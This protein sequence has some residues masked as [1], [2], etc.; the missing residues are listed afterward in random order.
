MASVGNTSAT[1]PI[2]TT[3]FDTA[4]CVIP[5]LNQCTEINTL[6]S[7][8]DKSWGRWPQHINLVY[9]FVHPEKLPE[10]K[11]RIEAALS[12]S[13][14]VAS[15]GASL[16]QPGYF[17][18]RK[19]YTVFL[20]ESD[21][22]TTALESLR[23]T[24]LE[25]LGQPSTPYKLHLTVG[26]SVDK[27]E[28]ARDFLLDKVRR[29]PC[30]KFPITSLAIL[31]RETPAK[32]QREASRM[33]LW[34]VIS[35]GSAEFIPKPSEFW[36]SY[37]NERGPTS[38]PDSAVAEHGFDGAH[39]L[40][41]DRR[42][43]SEVAYAYNQGTW[44]PC[45]GEECTI[46]L[47]RSL[48]VSSYNVLIDSEYPPAR[49]RDPL[50]LEAILSDT[51]AADILVLQEVSDDFLSY[52]LATPEIQRRY[53]YCSHGSPDQPDTGPLPNLRNIVLLSRM[54]FTWETVPFQ[55]RH[56]GALVA[57]FGA[58]ENGPSDFHFIVAG[59]HLTCGLTDGSVAAKKAQL[60]NLLSFLQQRHSTKPWIIAG[61]FNITTSTYTIEFALK[62]RSITQETGST[63]R[64]IETMIA[65]A[66]L[67][68]TWSV[69]RIEATD[70]PLPEPDDLYDGEFGATFNP[71]TNIL[72][73]ATS[74]TSNNRPQ[75]YDRILLRGMDKLRISQ[76]NHFG[77][78]GDKS[79]RSGTPSDHWGIRASLQLLPRTGD[80]AG[81]ESQ[82]LKHRPIDLQDVSTG[83]TDPWDLHAA[84]AA[85]GM[86]PTEENVEAFK[87]AFTRLKDVL[88]GP[89]EERM[90]QVPLVIIPVGSY[91]LDV[92]T[93][94]SDIDCL[95]VGTMSPKTFF[96]LARQRIR[97]AGVSG[98]RLIRKVEAKT[99]IMFELTV[100]GINV[101][102]QYCPG[103]RLL[104]RWS[105]LPN[106]HPTDPVFDLPM[107]SLR[108]LKPYRDLVYIQRTLPSL[109]AFRLAYRAIKLWALQRGVYS[110]KFGFLGG[111]HITLM[112]A[113]ICKGL[114]HVA[115]A[116]TAPALVKIFFHHYAHFDWKND[117]VFDPFFHK[118]RPRYHRS[119]REPMVVLGYHAPNSNAAHTSTGPGLATLVKEFKIADQRLSAVG[120]SWD[121]FFTVP[122]GAE[123]YLSEFLGSHD[124]YAQIS[125]QYWGRSLSRDKGLIGWVESRSLLLVVDIHKALPDIEV[126]I[127]PS[128]LSNRGPENTETGYEGCFV[129]GISWKSYATK[130]RRLQLFESLQ[131][132]FSRFLDTIR[133]EE[134]NYDRNTC[135]VD[136]SLVS[137]AQVKDLRPEST[138]W[139]DYVADADLD[140][141]DEED[142]IGNS[143]EDSHQPTIPY[144]PIR[145]P[146]TS[147][148]EVKSKLRPASDVL[149]RLRWDPGC[150]PGA[151]IVGY[152][153]R[154]VGAKEMDL[155]RWKSESTHDEFVP[156][157]RI[158][159]F[160]R[161]ADGVVVWD[162]N[163]RLDRIFGSGIGDRE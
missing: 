5:P 27:T 154:F 43:P 122:G 19:E 114:V 117:M 162:R 34:G 72:A 108:K 69:A 24:V 111:I 15:L 81:N 112:L 134:K 55:R 73:A 52:I 87:S 71:R 107:L 115:G 136:I 155:E 12:S 157:H 85:R 109:G 149:N 2:A 33:R 113:S 101:D 83:L 90:P 79:D 118:T 102:L 124:G 17:E 146:R 1:K 20:G 94:T 104:E 97:R 59:V 37:P 26:Q 25:A 145:P 143:N 22:P 142:D 9:P 95:C 47:D 29:L 75:R 49:E 32:H 135:W 45:A 129:I 133:G 156:M 39:A 120:M 21:S 99:G 103:G 150:N 50:L 58:S 63:L 140:S 144:V 141:D 152:E 138:D 35:L 131:K 110:S 89:T 56:K 4:L 91:A 130:D 70:D 61:D 53:P 31:V 8:Y 65:E 48:T 28:A 96:K 119:A 46:N 82:P 10:A 127:W 84:L 3:S 30:L 42:A 6:R 123:N 160:R 64:N 77:L 76:F 68:D 132:A 62:H 121:Q 86:I 13:A 128:R 44:A 148:V 66:E 80:C 60:Q 7:L 163:A 74:G 153:D 116:V 161:K 40:P 106:L 158:L 54:P 11:V 18:H 137:P 139:G 126:R 159:Y 67:L 16:E 57:S 151:F 78:P 41:A 23:C 105:E 51:A 147:A 125:M 36:L 88:L 14:S 92:W 38:R 93:S 100:R 98:I